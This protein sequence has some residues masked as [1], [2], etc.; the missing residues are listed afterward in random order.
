MKKRSI[1]TAPAAV[2]LVIMGLVSAALPARA[3]QD[4][5]F[6]YSTPVQANISI[7]SGDCDNSGGPT[8]TLGGEII[9][10]QFKANLTYYQNVKKNLT[11]Y[12]QD[13][14]ILLDAGTSI[15]IPK[16]PHQ[17]G[18]GGNPYIWVQFF[19]D[20]GANGGPGT[21][22]SDKLYLGRCVQGF[23]ID[24]SFLIDVIGNSHVHTQGCNNRGGPNITLS[25]TLTVASGLFATFTF[26]NQG[27][28]NPSGQGLPVYT[29]TTD[30]ALLVRDTDL[31]VPDVQFK[32]T[33]GGN[34]FIK[35]QF[36]QNSDP[37]TDLI[38]LGRCNQL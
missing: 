27:P 25:G 4:I 14:Q 1:C 2:A 10:G 24:P 28:D 23:Q 22:M 30:V 35:I 36:F 6:Q 29:A 18:V 31:I 21:A 20:D 7:S 3:D 33:V 12:G 32:G 34:P 5:S 26:S 8:I 13:A 17:G 19:K 15:T 38:T 16:S 9:L 37:V 11:L